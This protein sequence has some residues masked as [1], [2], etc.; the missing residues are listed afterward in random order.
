MNWEQDYRDMSHSELV[1]GTPYTPEDFQRL[2]DIVVHLQTSRNLL[3]LENMAYHG[4]HDGLTYMQYVMENQ[5]TLEKEISH[6]K[7]II[8]DQDGQISS[9]TDVLD[10][11]R[12][13]HGRLE[14]DKDNL[15]RKLINY[16]KPNDLLYVLHKLIDNQSGKAVGIVLAAATYKYKWLIKTPSEKEFND[17]FKGIVNTKCSFRAIS[18][19]MKKPSLPELKYLDPEVAQFEIKI[20]DF[21]VERDKIQ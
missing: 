1:F 20:E 2:R 3:M 18:K 11:Y 6:L 10:E 21:I 16:A 7:W 8:D 5:K 4:N 9:L 14:S 13:K 15:F 17:E 19:F 12:C